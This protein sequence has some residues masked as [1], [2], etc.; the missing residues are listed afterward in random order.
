M[1]N[2]ESIRDFKYL[3]Q[4]TSHNAYTPSLRGY[5]TKIKQNRIN[6]AIG[7]YL[8]LSIATAAAAAQICADCKRFCRICQQKIKFNF[9]NNF[10][11][12][13]CLCHEALS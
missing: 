4:T 12:R 5:G 1:L 9:P 11:F 3:L 13:L 6:I 10:H 8:N 7:I 2:I